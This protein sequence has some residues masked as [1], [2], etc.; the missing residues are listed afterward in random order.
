MGA[1][2]GTP[3]K[4]HIWR[5]EM[6]SPKGSSASVVLFQGLR[7]ATPQHKMAGHRIWQKCVWST[8]FSSLPSLEA[9]DLSLLGLRGIGRTFV[10]QNL[11]LF[12]HRII[13]FPGLYL[14]IRIRPFTFQAQHKIR[15]LYYCCDCN[16]VCNCHCYYDYDYRYDYYYWSTNSQSSGLVWLIASHQTDLSNH[17]TPHFISSLLHRARGPLLFDWT[18]PCIQSSKRCAVFIREMET[19]RPPLVLCLVIHQPPWQKIVS[20]FSYQFVWLQFPPTGSSH[21]FLYWIKE[22]FSTQSVFSM[23]VHTVFES[24]LNLPFDKWNRWSLYLQY[25]NHSEGSFLLP[26]WLCK[27]FLKR[28]QRN[29]FNDGFTTAGGKEKPHICMPYLQG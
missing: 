14:L 20:N 15:T 26:Y 5:N 10:A 1:G 12:P 24:S 16:C 22:P 9:E 18:I 3:W 8:V 21:A 2:A 13:Q 28:T 29:Y 27:F 25:K 7:G 11:T 6:S 23:K 19:L 4:W 17:K